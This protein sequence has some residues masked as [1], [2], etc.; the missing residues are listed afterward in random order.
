M[1]D[2]NGYKKWTYKDAQ[3]VMEDIDKYG[4]GDEYSDVEK[5]HAKKLIQQ[6]NAEQS[7]KKK[8]GFGALKSV[9]R[10]NQALEDITQYE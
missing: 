3:I 8:K 2:P 7:K 10:R 9:Q 1:P 4:L 6:Y 5:A